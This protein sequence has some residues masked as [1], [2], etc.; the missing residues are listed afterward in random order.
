MEFPFFNTQQHVHATSRHSISQISSS[1]LFIITA[2]DHSECCNLC[3]V[4]A[5]RKAGP[6]RTVCG[7][8]SKCAAPDRLVE[9]TLFIFL[10]SSSGGI[11]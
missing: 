6:Y 5:I 1:D 8:A 4:R 3:K 9:L 7:N 2:S 10:F 11:G